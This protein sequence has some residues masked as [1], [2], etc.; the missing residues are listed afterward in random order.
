MADDKYKS[1]PYSKTNPPVFK[2]PRRWRA[3]WDDEYQRYYYVDLLNNNKSQ[4]EPPVGTEPTEKTVA[5][6]ASFNQSQYYQ[7]AANTNK[8][9]PQQ[10][11]VPQQQYYPQQG[12]YP[13]Q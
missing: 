6:N 9:M 3:E 4:W 12:Y 13:Q 10:Q 5:P 11:Y 8:S 7:P 1:F 2:E